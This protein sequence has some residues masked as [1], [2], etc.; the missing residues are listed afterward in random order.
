MAKRRKKK[1]KKGKSWNQIKFAFKIWLR[2]WSLELSTALTIMCIAFII[3]G[4]L[5]LFV[6][7]EHGSMIPAP[8]DQ[9]V[10]YLH[11]DNDQ[12]LH[13]DLCLFPTGILVVMFSAW[14]MGDGLYKRS[15]FNELIDTESKSQFIEDLDEIEELAWKLTTK[16]EMMVVD[17]KKELGIR[18]KKRRRK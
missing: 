15:R 18:K 9:W 7:D 12:D 16:H 13:Y 11:G 14:Y 8:L 5:A 10:M 4:A 1:K 3:F 2:D 6:I 17:K